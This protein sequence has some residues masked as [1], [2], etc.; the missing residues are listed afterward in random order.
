MDIKLEDR[1]SMKQPLAQ[2]KDFR[3]SSIISSNNQVLFVG[4]KVIDAQS[5]EQ[6]VKL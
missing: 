1:D 3:P 6:K 2:I 4:G 5:V